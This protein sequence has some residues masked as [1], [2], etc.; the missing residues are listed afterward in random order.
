MKFGEIKTDDAL[1]AI[2]AHTLRSGELVIKKGSVLTGAHLKEIKAA[3]IDSVTAALLEMGDMGEDAVAHAIATRL[4]GNGVGITD[5]TSG[6]CN[7]YAKTGGIL[8][9]DIGAING[10]NASGDGVLCS[11]IPSFAVAEAGQT[12]ATVKVIPYAVAGNICDA[13]LNVAGSG[14][15]NVQ[16][17]KNKR[18]GLVLSEVAGAKQSLL[19]KARE[20]INARV[21]TLG[22]AVVHNVRIAHEREPLA[23]AVRAAAEIC[24]VVLVLGGASTVDVGDTVPAAIVE[25]GGEVD[26]FGIPV[27]P[28]N[29][30]VSGTI[31]HVP[32]LGLPG[33]A[34]SPKMNGVDLILPR[35]F[36]G[37]DISPET[38]LGLGVGGLLH[39]VSE[40]PAPRE[41]H[42]TAKYGNKAGD[43][44]ANVAA[45]VL[46][47]GSSRRMGV[48]NKLLKEID[49]QAMVC[50]V[51]KAAKKSSAGMVI[52]VTGHQAAEIR[53]ALKDMDVTFVHNAHFEEGLSTSVRTGIGHVPGDCS[54]ALMVLGDMPNVSSDIMNTLIN[55]F[56]S[57]DATAI[58][59][60]THNGKRGNPM[61]WPREFFPDMLDLTGDTGAR[62]LAQRYNERVVEVAVKNDGI[63][64]DVDTPDDLDAI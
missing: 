23:G 63:F 47:A 32:V 35:L 4:A 40:R 3:G 16:G 61:V 25:A 48:E 31:G 1:G 13:L 44:G 55:A 54:G 10:L 19:D 24:D 9:L 6:R 15:I 45:V 29:L 36:A 60:P 58:C 57:H 26:L 37:M 30:L 33:C 38:L 62:K 39:D 22:S 14:A 5:A 56:N 42:H 51:V 17:F 59:A 53:S 49:G 28:G 12:I 43:K 50:H 21:E 52:V 11:T 34:R 27:D 2:L 7:L 8:D 20:V 64:L 46:A 18:T 41:A